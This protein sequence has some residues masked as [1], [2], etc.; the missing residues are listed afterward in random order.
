MVSDEE[1]NRGYPD[2]DKVVHL[3]EPC[4]CPSTCEKKIVGTIYSGGHVIWCRN[5]G[6]TYDEKHLRPIRI[7]HQFGSDKLCVNTGIYPKRR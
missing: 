2:W 4:D 5:C 7:T 3:K 1:W 6:C